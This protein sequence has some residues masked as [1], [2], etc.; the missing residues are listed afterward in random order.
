M[1]RVL[2]DTLSD[3]SRVL[4]DKA[5][6]SVERED[7]ELMR[8]TTRDGSVYHGNLVVGADGVHSRVRAE[9]WRLANSKSPGA[10]PE[11]EMSCR[12]CHFEGKVRYKA[13]Y[14][15]VF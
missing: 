2:Y 8:V 3:S 6:V 14:G 10:F 5:V 1:L 7:S 4:V 12:Y 13:D 15:L 9:M 11:R